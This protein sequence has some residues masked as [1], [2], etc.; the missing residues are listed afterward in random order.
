MLPA[1]TVVPYAIKGLLYTNRMRLS[2]VTISSLLQAQRDVHINVKPSSTSVGLLGLSGELVHSIC[3][4]GVY[5]YTSSDKGDKN[6]HTTIGIP[7]IQCIHLTEGNQCLY[8]L[9]N[10]KN[11]QRCLS[12]KYIF[13]PNKTTEKKYYIKK[14][15]VTECT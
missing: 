4:T 13:I 9:L 11:K 5:G 1:L 6:R 15:N 7:T 12:T 2:R 8:I 14:I 3:R 10:V